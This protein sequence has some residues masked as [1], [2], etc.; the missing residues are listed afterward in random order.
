MTPTTAPPGA[1]PFRNLLVLPDALRYVLW[2]VTGTRSDFWC[3]LKDGPRIHM[4]GAPSLDWETV[5]EIF[6]L[7]QYDTGLDPRHVRRVVDVGAN[8]GYSCLLWCWQFPQARVLAYEPHPTHHRIL[9]RQLKANGY[10]DRVTVVPAAATS[11]A[12]TS[13]LVDAD[14]CSTVV[15]SSSAAPA[16][17]G[18]VRIDTVDFFETAGPEPIDLLKIDI[19]GGEYELMQDPRFDE[20]ALRVGAVLMEWHKLTPEHLGP[21]WCANRLRGLGFD[22]QVL[23]P[24][25]PGERTGLLL[26]KRPAAQA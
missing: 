25:A 15:A 21:E 13:F 3:R 5:Y 1:T 17:Q 14:R 4:R 9:E 19:E 24:I 23:T 26:A 6:R 8:V 22:V 12:S 2:K 7:H 18:V 16:G 10:A 20:L 11:R